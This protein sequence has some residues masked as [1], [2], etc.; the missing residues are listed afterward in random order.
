MIVFDT[1]QR[2]FTD[3]LVVDERIPLRICDLMGYRVGILP[4]RVAFHVQILA[5][6]VA[7][8]AVSNLLAEVTWYGVVLPRK[9]NRRETAVLVGLGIVIPVALGLPFYFIN[10]VDLRSTTLRFGC[11]LL[12][13]VVPFKCLE[14]LFSVGSPDGGP[15]I[16]TES[17]QHCV[18]YMGFLFNPI[19][20]AKNENGRVVVPLTTETFLGTCKRYLGWLAVSVLVFHFLLP[21][22]FRPFPEQDPGRDPSRDLYPTFELARMYNT[23]VQAI[24]LFLTFVFSLYGVAMVCSIAADMQVCDTVFDSQPLFRATSPSDF[25]GRRWNNLVHHNLKEGVY[26]PVRSLVGWKYRHSKPM[27]VLATFIA[28]GLLHEYVWALLFFRTDQA[29]SEGDAC[30]TCHTYAFGK[31]LIFF[32]WN[33]LLLL[34][35]ESRLGKI[36]GGVFGARL[37]PLPALIRSHLVILTALPVAHLFTE[38]LLDGGYFAHLKL[39][40]PLLAIEQA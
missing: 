3:K 30:Q 29:L 27:G 25:W 32:F 33:G 15:K 38:D 6:I 20:A 28:S 39:A 1:V 22:N 11:I 23:Y 5:L 17:L 12:P 8:I 10:L 16:W 14:A 18:Y 24:A 35:E 19:Y 4:P 9:R 7:Q 13:L 34:L 26:K 31:Q 37:E 21:C 36:L 2:F 40:F